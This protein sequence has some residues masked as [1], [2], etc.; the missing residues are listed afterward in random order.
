MDTSEDEEDFKGDTQRNIL[1]KEHMREGP[2]NPNAEVW[3]EIWDEDLPRKC[4]KHNW[5]QEEVKII[6]T[7]GARARREPKEPKDDF[8][9]PSDSNGVRLVPK[10]DVDSVVGDTNEVLDWESQGNY[11]DDYTPLTWEEM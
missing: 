8:T 4:P 11:F 6:G 2:S 5:A 9:F 1:H 7:L 3:E 10:I